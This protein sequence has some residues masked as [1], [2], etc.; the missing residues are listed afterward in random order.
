MRQ[1]LVFWMMV[2][3]CAAA[4]L[5]AVTGALAEDAQRAMAAPAPAV[6]S[7]DED[8]DDQDERCGDMDGDGV[9]DASSSSSPRSTVSICGLPQKSKRVCKSLPHKGFSSL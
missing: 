6:E 9:L 8:C 3:C 7:P 1:R 5:L 2:A 4:P